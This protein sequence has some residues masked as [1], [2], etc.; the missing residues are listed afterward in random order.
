MML[1]Q[2][3]RAAWLLHGQM[4]TSVH[5]VAAMLQVHYFV[6]RV[7]QW[8]RV[9]GKEAAVAERDIAATGTAAGPELL[10]DSRRQEAQ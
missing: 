8:V 7:I 10:A 4:V 5:C 9:L 6:S 1:M 3:T 2:G